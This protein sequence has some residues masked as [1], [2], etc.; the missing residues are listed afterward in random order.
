MNI[1]CTAAIA[2]ACAMALSSCGK[3]ETPIAQQAAGEA[4]VADETASAHISNAAASATEAMSQNVKANAANAA[5]TAGEIAATAD[6][7]TVNARRNI[8]AATQPLQNAYQQGKTNEQQQIQTGQGA[9]PP[10]SQ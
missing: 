4:A 2:L 3:P 6:A 7:A 1:K 10:P 8:D 5:E 9:V